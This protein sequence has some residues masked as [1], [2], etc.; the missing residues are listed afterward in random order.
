MKQDNVGTE[1]HK[2]TVRCAEIHINIK[3]MNDVRKQG[4]DL[5]SLSFKKNANI[6]KHLFL[7]GKYE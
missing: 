2:H 7:R 3:K 5:L 1:L 4:A 6:N